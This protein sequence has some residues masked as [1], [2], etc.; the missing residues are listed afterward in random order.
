M[1]LISRCGSAAMSGL[2]SACLTVGPMAPLPVAGLVLVG[3]ATDQLTLAA[4][5]LSD[6]QSVEAGLANLA[7]SLSADTKAAI[8]LAL[9][10]A[11]KALQ[12]I[13]PGGILA[14]TTAAAVFQDLETAATLAGKYVPGAAT[15]P[16]FLAVSALLPMI[17]GAW[18][19]VA[20]AGALLG[21]MSPADAR[22]VLAPL[23]AARLVK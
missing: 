15:N 6:V 11:Q 4:N 9:S 8:A 2:L 13:A 3:C 1:R 21:G 23:R 22:I 7:T 12:D 18:A 20:A 16:I 17:A 10:N 19:L 14:P 5:V